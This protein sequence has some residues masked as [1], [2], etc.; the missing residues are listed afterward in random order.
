MED[1]LWRAFGPPHGVQVI[2]GPGQTRKG[3]KTAFLTLSPLLD[4]QLFLTLPGHSG[5]LDVGGEAVPPQRAGQGSVVVE[6]ATH[7]ERIYI[8]IRKTANV[9][10]AGLRTDHLHLKNRLFWYNRSQK[11]YNGFLL[12]FQ[13]A[14]VRA[15]VTLG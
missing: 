2:R 4:S 8:A 12:T 15:Q 7:L 3:R 13:W 5:A 6:R 14:P 9:L 1:Y 10:L 11:T